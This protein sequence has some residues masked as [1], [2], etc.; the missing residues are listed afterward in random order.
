MNT[1]GY[2]ESKDR[3]EAMA[4]YARLYAQHRTL[5]FLV[6][7][8]VFFAMFAAIS[9][10]SLSFGFAIVFG[11]PILITLSVV[12][13]VSVCALCIWLSV[14][15]WG[16]KYIWRYG[17]SLYDS[18]GH[19]SVKE[20][21]QIVHPWW[22]YVVPVLPVVAGFVQYGLAAAD[23]LPTRFTQ[24]ISI[25]YFVP[26][27]IVMY[28]LQRPAIGIWMLLAPALFLAYALLVLAGAPLASDR[29]SMFWLNLYVP[30]FGSLVA[31]M[32]AGHIYGRYALRRLKS[33]AH[34][35]PQETS[36]D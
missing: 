28:R 26:Y 33:L 16:G 4:K 14:F 27:C 18:D 30:M 13:V 35:D 25:L 23:W 12:L 10:A 19:A 5:P 15:R 20:F 2:Q 3:H 9:G 29:F 34:L 1:N 7:F 32:V 17:M 11:N 24:P 6:Q 8:G 21:S 31:A 36:H 22:F